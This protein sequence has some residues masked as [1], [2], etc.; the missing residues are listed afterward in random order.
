MD[1]WYSVV[2]GWISQDLLIAGE[3]WAG[4]LQ[5][6]CYLVEGGMVR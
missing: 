3:N 4:L 6:T 5:I 2:R 1:P